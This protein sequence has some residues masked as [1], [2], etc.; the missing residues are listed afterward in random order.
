MEKRYLLFFVLT[1]LAVFGYAQLRLLLAPPPARNNG[2]PPAVGEQDAGLLNGHDESEP[3]AIPEPVEV[4]ESTD[5]GVGSSLSD[6]AQ[7]DVEVPLPSI[8]PEYVTLGSADSQDPYNILVILNSRGAAIEVIELNSPVYRDVGTIENMQRFGHK[9]S[10]YLGSLALTEL[11]NRSGTKINVVGPGTPAAKARAL[12]SS[13]DDGLRSGD[14]IKM[15]DG[16]EVVGVQSFLDRIGAM[17][18]GQNVELSVERIV[19]GTPQTFDFEIELEQPRLKLIQVEENLDQGE[20]EDAE[21]SGRH[22]HVLSFQMALERVGSVS[23]GSGQEEISKLP[24]LRNGTWQ[25][26]HRPS[27]DVGEQ[28]VEFTMELGPNQLR[29]IGQTGGLRIVRRYRLEPNPESEADTHERRRY[30]LKMEIEIQNLAQQPQQ[31]AYRLDG[32]TGLPTE[33]WWYLYKVHPRMWHR[34][35]SRDVVW[36]SQQG[37][38]LFGCTDISK[39]AQGSPKNPVTKLNETNSD[40]LMY[41]GVDT[42]Y[43]AAVLLADRDVPQASQPLALSSAVA[44]PVGPIFPKRLNLT[45]VSFRLVSRTVTVQPNEKLTQSFVI[46]AGPKD[47]AVLAEYGLSKLIVYGWFAKVAKLMSWLLHRFYWVTTLGGLTAGSYALA[48]IMLTVL[49]RGCMFP[50]GLRQAKMAAKMQ[51]LA[52]EMKKIADK[53]KND[54]EKKA[55]AQKELFKKHNYNPLSGCLPMIV[56]LPIFIGLYRAL[57]VDMKL[58][59]AAMIPG[60]SWCSNLAAPDKLW[61]WESLIPEFLSS[62]TGF[63]GPFLNV[64]PLITIVF[65]MTHQKLFTP[66]ATDDQTRM[67]HQMM[68]FMMI[69]MGFIFFK[70]AAGL[71]IYIIASSAWGVAERLLLPKTKPKAEDVPPTETKR[72]ARSSGPN[73]SPKS[74]SKSKKKKAKGRQ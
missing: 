8:P 57:S 68:K 44:R 52:P 7:N 66:P 59:G 69:F 3:E 18:P 53:Y 54:M 27:T 11:E 4:A 71:C 26:T 62:P 24:S 1:F 74:S 63:L 21:K 29:K 60:M 49:V 20:M 65:F 43:F 47:A 5:P 58:R 50:L 41:A 23:I 37:H 25:I 31:I 33:G 56:Q 70:V 28:V 34:A 40:Q 73:G 10:G 12:T 72:V 51:E 45:N 16:E 32:P 2:N 64:L 35:G 6:V 22:D 36:G 48:I 38:Q 42:Q 9:V 30:H 15:V 55:K 13:T 61:Y 19:N 39:H 17:L 14:V 46:F 67:Q